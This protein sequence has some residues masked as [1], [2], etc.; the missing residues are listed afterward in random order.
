MVPVDV[1]S[2]VVAGP[3]FLLCPQPFLL[4]VLLDGFK[5]R[6]DGR[7]VR[8]LIVHEFVEWGAWVFAA[9]TAEF[10]ILVLR[11]LPELAFFDIC[12]DAITLATIAVRCAACPTVETARTVS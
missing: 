9:E 4:P 5:I 2:A 1:G 8:P 7:V 3:F 6:S 11:A 12:I 10:D